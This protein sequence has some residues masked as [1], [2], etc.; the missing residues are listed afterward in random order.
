MKHH[1]AKTANFYQ[2]L[3][4]IKH[5]LA[6]GVFCFMIVIICHQKKELLVILANLLPQGFS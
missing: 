6:S 4:L 3:T 1:T 5:Y 2:G